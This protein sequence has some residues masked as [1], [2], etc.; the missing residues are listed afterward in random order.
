[1]KFLVGLHGSYYAVRSQLLF[2]SPLPF[3]GRVF[4]LLLQDESQRSF[5]NAVG[6]SID[7]QA[8]VPEQYVNQSSRPGSTY[9]NQFTKQKRKVDAIY[10]H[11]GYLGHLV[12][13]C[14]QLIGYPPRWKGQEEKRFVSTPTIGKNFQR[15]SIANNIV[16]LEQNSGTPNI[17]FSQEHIQNLFT[18]TNSISNSNLNST[19]NVASASGMSFSCH[20]I[21]SSQNQFTWILDTGATNHIICS[22]LL[23]DSIVLSKTLSKV[24]LP[25]GQTVP[26][27]F[28]ATV[29]FSPNI[30]LHNALYVPSFTVNLVSVSR[31]TADNSIGLFFL[32]TKCILQD[33]SK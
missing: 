7:S 18:L 24:H 27:V 15:L 12:D 30:V 9:T 13:K 6:I 2:Q 25:N 8:M 11:C 16:V 23:F 14:F 5:T 26:I 1:M 33:L 31:L 29:K 4:S 28:T 10:S 17:V 3:M 19:P 21:S 22:P 20:T 32:Q